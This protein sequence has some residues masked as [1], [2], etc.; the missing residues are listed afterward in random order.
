M[1][2]QSALSREGLLIVM[3]RDIVFVRTKKRAIAK[4]TG[5]NEMQRVKAF[6]KSREQRIGFF[7]KV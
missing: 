1:L 2:A 5:T 7:S 4:L 6:D 3:M